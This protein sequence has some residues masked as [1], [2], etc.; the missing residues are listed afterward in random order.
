MFLWSKV[1]RVR[2]YDNLTAIYGPTLPQFLDTQLRNSSEIV[3]LTCRPP[4][5]PRKI[6]STDL[7]DGWE[8]GKQRLRLCLD[9]LI[10]GQETEK[11]RWLRDGHAAV[12]GWGNSRPWTA[13]NACLIIAS[14]SAARFPRL[15]QNLMLA[16]PLSDPSR[17]HIKPDT[18]LQI[19]GKKRG[20]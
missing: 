7:C 5:A 15:A 19:E 17:N 9:R 2:K 18:R 10:C 1:R 20:K 8:C 12:S 6:S 16:V 4:F 3:T 13:R 11:C 14:V